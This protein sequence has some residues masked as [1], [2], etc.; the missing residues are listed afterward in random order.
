[1][2]SRLEDLKQ[3]DYQVTSCSR[4]LDNE[5][6]PSSHANPSRIPQQN[7]VIETKQNTNYLILISIKIS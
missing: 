6:H 2:C 4:Q 7:Q 3:S 5:T 1:M